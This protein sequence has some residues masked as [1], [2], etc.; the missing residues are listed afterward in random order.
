[1]FCPLTSPGC[2]EASFDILFD[3][4][5][6]AFGALFETAEVLAVITRRGAYYYYGDLR[7]GQGREA[8]LDALRSD[9]DLKA[10]IESDM[11][12]AMENS[13]GFAGA[14]APE[15]EEDLDLVR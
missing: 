3:R 8:A 9:D 12:A 10:K 14:G 2:R 5:I 11:R 6:D 1:M 13:G 7:L 4:G 15:E